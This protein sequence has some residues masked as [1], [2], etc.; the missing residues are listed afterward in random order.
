MKQRG[1]SV[2]DTIISNSLS[3]TPQNELLVKDFKMLINSLQADL[4]LAE[5]LLICKMM[6]PKK[7]GMVNIEE[8]LK[9]F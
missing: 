5:K 9:H 4:T 3:L 2:W 1:V 7:T 8:F 6:D